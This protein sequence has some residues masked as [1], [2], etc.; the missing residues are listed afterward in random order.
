M[1][2]KHYLV[3]VK[4]KGISKNI[5][6]KIKFDD[7]K[8]VITVSSKI[9]NN[10]KRFYE[11]FCKGK[12]EYENLSIINMLK[13]TNSSMNGYNVL[14]SIDKDIKNLSITK[15]MYTLNSDKHKM[16]LM[17]INK[18][19]INPFDDKRFICDDGITTQ[20][21]GFESLYFI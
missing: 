4:L 6:K 8:N 18:M 5:V 2:I 21:H 14:S 13:P 3:M 20:P 11:E 10:Y 16:F 15:T 1:H 19:A 9:Y 12:E 17:K 7:Y